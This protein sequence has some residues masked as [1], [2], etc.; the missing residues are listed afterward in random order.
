MLPDRE[1][2]SHSACLQKWI[3]LQ[4][5]ESFWRSNAEQ[6]GLPPLAALDTTVSA[7]PASF[8]LD[9][10][11]AVGPYNLSSA[12][13]VYDCPGVIQGVADTVFAIT[14]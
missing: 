11:A 6:D 3:L 8:Q 13:S 12:E 7:L 9:N 4:A 14:G 2:A 5:F 1:S 10:T